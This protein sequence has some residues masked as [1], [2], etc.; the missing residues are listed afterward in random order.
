MELT[1]ALAILT[2]PKHA[3]VRFHAFDGSRQWLNQLQAV[4]FLSR[5]DLGQIKICGT[6]TEVRRIKH[7]AKAPDPL[8]VVAIDSRDF[9]SRWIGARR[10]NGGMPV[11]Q[12]SLEWVRSIYGLPD[13]YLAFG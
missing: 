6:P 13:T 9:T 10:A 1:V 3:K 2:G 12:P 11:L 8:P 5:K 7:L 4:Q